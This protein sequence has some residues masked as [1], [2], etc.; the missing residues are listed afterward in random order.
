MYI[1]IDKPYK[2]NIEKETVA[3]NMQYDVIYEN[4]KHSPHNIVIIQGFIHML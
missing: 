1:N 4:V 2:Y 3:G